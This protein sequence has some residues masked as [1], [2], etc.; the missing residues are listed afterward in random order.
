MTSRARRS[1]VLAG[2]DIT[3]A[4][5]TARSPRGGSG[6]TH[7]GD[8]IFTPLKFSTFTAKNRI[9]R[10]SI[11]GRFDDYNGRGTQIRINWE[12]KFARGGVGAIIS[13]HVPVSV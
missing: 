4:F 6:M 8:P 1:I 11:S 7:S 12:V 13:S 5:I 3:W 10:S 9:F 2:A